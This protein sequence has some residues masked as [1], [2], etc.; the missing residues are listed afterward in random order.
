MTANNK[1]RNDPEYAEK[2]RECNRRN[3]YK[4]IELPR[5]NQLKRQEDKR[6]LKEA[7]KINNL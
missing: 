1:Y 4:Y 2:Q 5:V 7:S 6:I 3:S